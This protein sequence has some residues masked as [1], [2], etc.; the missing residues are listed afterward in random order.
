LKRRKERYRIRNKKEV[1]RKILIKKEEM[2]GRKEGRNKGE[3]K[4][5]RGAKLRKI[6]ITSEVQKRQSRSLFGIFSFFNKIF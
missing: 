6:T 4:G 3:E 1:E 5:K 2:D